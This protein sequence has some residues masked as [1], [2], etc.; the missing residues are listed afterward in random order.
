MQGIAFGSGAPGQT[1]PAWTTRILHT[2]TVLGGPGIFLLAFLDSSI[3]SFPVVID[4]LVMEQSIAHPARMPYLAAVAVAGSLSG[5]IL[6]YWLAWRGGETFYHRLSKMTSR[7]F[8]RWM[9]RN[10]FVCLFAASLLPP[11]MPFKPFIILAGILEVRART[12]ATAVVTGRG[13][14]YL[15]E[16][17]L[18]I[19]YGP[20]SIHFVEAHKWGFAGIALCVVVLLAAAR[21]LLSR[22]LPAAG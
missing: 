7:H 8:H 2:L 18:A 15:G 16:G 20:Q 1:G 13:V 19:H 21:R 22:A 9:E 11:P 14:R 12:F 10:A 6:L 17:L 3:L 5:C 4:L